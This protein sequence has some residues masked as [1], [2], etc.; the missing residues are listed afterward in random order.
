[1]NS[2]R[3]NNNREM[4]HGYREGNGRRF[5]RAEFRK[6]GQREQCDVEKL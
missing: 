4:R 1:M 2:K 6:Y 5:G 3:C